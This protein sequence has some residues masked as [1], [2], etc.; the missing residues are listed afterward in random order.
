[1]FGKRYV[2]LLFALFAAGFALGF[3]GRI[4]ILFFLAGF[5]M[6]AV[7]LGG[8]VIH[9]AKIRL[10]IWQMRRAGDLTRRKEDGVWVYELTDAG[11]QR[12]DE[13]TARETDTRTSTHEMRKRG[14]HPPLNG[15][16]VASRHTMRGNWRPR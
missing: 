2:A 13:R 12:Y 1:M 6:L 10:A 15:F 7:L 4:A 3:A 9:S 8:R 16:E 14:D 5:V 11:R